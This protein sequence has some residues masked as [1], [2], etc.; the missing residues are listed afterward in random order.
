MATQHGVHCAALSLEHPKSLSL[1]QYCTPLPSRFTSV[2]SSP[3]KH[4]FGRH[5]NA[6]AS[7]EIDRPSDPSKV[8]IS[9]PVICCSLLASFHCST[10]TLR[11]TPLPA[12]AARRSS[13]FS[14]SKGP[15]RMPPQTCAAD[16]PSH[17]SA[18]MRYCVHNVLNADRHNVSFWTRSR[19]ARV[20]CRIFCPGSSS[21]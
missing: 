6:C 9:K 14:C 20:H 18:M 16:C 5:P 7:M 1:Q 10:P 19:G 8:N 17:T 21:D 4:T 12:M 3:L 2:R 15:A 11:S 13:N